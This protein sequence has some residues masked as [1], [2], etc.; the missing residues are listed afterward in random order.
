MHLLAFDIQGEREACQRHDGSCSE[1]EVV[2]VVR[3]Q[4]SLTEVT[5]LPF[6][7]LLVI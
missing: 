2:I 7:G 3:I 5:V 6:S 1:T 4:L